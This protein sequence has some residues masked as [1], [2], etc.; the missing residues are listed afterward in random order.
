MR[1]KVILFYSRAGLPDSCSHTHRLPGPR[2]WDTVSTVPSLQTARTVF[3]D[4]QFPDR[5]NKRHCLVTHLYISW[6]FRLVV[7]FWVWTYPLL[8]IVNDY[9]LSSLIPSY[10]TSGTIGIY[11]FSF[12]SASGCFEAPVPFCSPVVLALLCFPE[13]RSFM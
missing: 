7:M 6:G 11:S 4:S 1:R 3:L 9:L 8:G 12:A 5:Q 2:S 10:P 13:L